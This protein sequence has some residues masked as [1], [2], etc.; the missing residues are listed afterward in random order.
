VVVV[1]LTEF[2]RSGSGA[3]AEFDRTPP[4]DLAAE[5]SVLGGMLLS[6][7]AIADVVEVLRE[8]D[9]YR[10]AHASVYDV[11]GEL[12][13]RGEPA[14][15]ISVAAELGKREM[16]DRVGGPAY[17]H[18]LI[19]SVPTAA[20]AGYY[21]RIV[22]EKAVLRR[23]AEAG[24]RIVQFAYSAAPDVDDLVDRAQAA[25]YDVTERRTTE[26]YAVLGDLLNPTL[27]E[28]ESIE[29]HDGSLTGVPTGFAD[30][31]ELTNGLHGG[32]LWIVAARPAVGKALALD[33]PLPTPSGWTT[34]GE[35]A[36]G[37]LL[38]GA[39]GKPT[40]VVA[41]TGVLSGRPCYEVEFSDESVIVADASHQWLTLARPARRRSLDGASCART[42]FIRPRVVTTEE[43]ESTVRCPTADGRLIH[44]MPVTQPFELPETALP[45]DP[46]LL[47]VWL[48]D[49]TSAAAQITTADP[50]IVAELESRGYVLKP[51]AAARFRYQ[52]RVP[53]DSPPGLM[54]QEQLRSL[55]ILEN[56]RIPA[57]YLRA[58]FRQRRDLLAGLLDV[59]GAVH[60]LGS[61]VHFAVT[62]R[63][64]A[65]DTREL[66]ASL[67]YAPLL[68]TRRAL[69]RSPEHSVHYTVSFGP[70][71]NVFR[72][73]RKTSRLRLSGHPEPRARFVRD[74]RPTGSVPVRCVEVDNADHLYL[75][76]PT[77]IP[78]HNSTL[79]LDLARAAAIKN[80]MGA[81]VFSLE[82]SRLEITMRLLSAEARVSLQS[83]RTG[84]LG[85][86][87]WARL[88]RR[89]GEVAEAPLFIDD[90]PNLTM[91]EIRA[92]ARRLKQREGLR[93]II[94]DYLQL[95]SSPRRVEN[96]QQEV[97]E[98]SR[99]LKLL[100]K[101]LDVPVVA[102]SQLNRASEQRADKRPQLSD[103]RECL[104]GDT[105]VTRADTGE[106][107]PIRDLVG[108]RDVPVWTLDEHLRLRRGIMAEVWPTGTRPVYRVTL[109]SG[110]EI[111][112]TS[113]H[114]LLTIHGWRPVEMLA[115]GDHLATARRIPDPAQPTRWSDDQVVLLAHM[116]GDGC[117]TRSPIYYCSRDEANLDAVETAVRRTFGV[118]TVRSVGRGVTYVHFPMSG[119]SGRG[120][121]NPFYDWLREIQVYGK[122]AYAKCVP[123]AVHMFDD[124]RIR[125]FL[126]HLWATDG[127]V[128]VS[129]SSSRVRVYYATTSPQ[130]A[131]DVHALLLRVGI[132]ARLRRQTKVPRHRQGWT[133]D[134]S[135]RE[136]LMRFLTTVG[137]H[138]ERGERCREA[139]EAMAGHAAN[140]NVDIIPGAVWDYARKAMLAAGV[141][142]RE[143][144]RRL[145]MSYFGSALYKSGLSRE[146]MARLAVA[147]P[148]TYLADLVTSDVRWDRVVRI[149]PAGEED[150][151]D[152]SVPGTHSFV[153]NG[154]ISHNSGA[155]EQ[156]A[157]AVV[158]LY[159]EDAVE[160]E[161]A[162]AGE[163][164]LIVAKHRNGPT[165]TITVAFQGHYSRFVDMAPQ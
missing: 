124:E 32:Q 42:P 108:Q 61:A 74:V 26:D 4:Q 66:I 134:V 90:S 13:G 163:A 159:R 87:D 127:S 79:G 147:V 141:T 138:G 144:A 69:G 76:G 36:V 91:M 156:D 107:V 82:M 49:S 132:G 95:M 146:R 50:E 28:I 89:M 93:L 139:L 19:S 25:V 157:D 58:G 88:A 165:G 112:A 110:R 37:D 126:R 116:L 115:P 125:L 111:V 129:S 122:H 65:Y 80:G 6:K 119:P 97:S 27:E 14:D 52:V 44:A 3:P 162:R 11:I 151:Y 148:D 12:Y 9:F 31:D 71:E 63:P 39:D 60:G 24:T 70:R 16:L 145:D 1:T 40:R 23:L 83:M 98:L 77:C 133:V 57:A 118:S 21:A 38:L 140:P 84:R 143:L 152:A 114:P 106:H 5:Q 86:D 53:E 103:L 35:V 18:T 154:I 62:N 135:G 46:Y 68:T 155:I 75:A 41:A 85:E 109:A 160:K 164:D 150:V 128:T 56:R 20:N 78:T 73:S 137:V 117:V 158:L 121:T 55:G 67:G 54:V 7:D 10:P 131:Q 101:E 17:L 45:I 130:L 30:L 34:M 92:K 96:R 51:S 142:A 43:L 99:N 8:G 123:A 94:L 161:S 149:E 72:L 47:G 2:P 104:V 153:A 100:A 64:L 33:T 120:L 136:D 15:V 48:G 102:I 22:A 29:G 81:I 105:R 113:N 59:A